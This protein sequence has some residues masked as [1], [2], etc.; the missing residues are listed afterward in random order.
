MWFRLLLLHTAAGWDKLSL[1]EADNK[2]SVYWDISNSLTIAQS[3]RSILKAVISTSLRII[4]FG[5]KA[6][7]YLHQQMPHEAWLV[8]TAGIF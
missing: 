1:Q 6:I 7:S 2:A 4:L 8:A 5:H 3:K